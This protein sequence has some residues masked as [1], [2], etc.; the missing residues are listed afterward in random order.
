[1]EGIRCKNNNV[2]AIPRDAYLNKLV[3]PL[4]VSETNA[5]QSVFTHCFRQLPY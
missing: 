2:A 3:R 1:M 4:N 5:D